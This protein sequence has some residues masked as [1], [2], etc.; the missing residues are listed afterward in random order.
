MLVR[1]YS[2]TCGFALGPKPG[3]QCGVR[4]VWAHGGERVS[5][6]WQSM[7]MER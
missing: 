7:E 1:E 3:L 5:R 6:V 2:C 4:P